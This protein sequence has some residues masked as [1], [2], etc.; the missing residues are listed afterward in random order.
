LCG[1]SAQLAEQR[2]QA[3]FRQT[4]ARARAVWKLA[5]SVLEHARL[6]WKPSN[7]G[8]GRPPGI[9]QCRRALGAAPSMRRQAPDTNAAAS[10]SRNTIAAETSASVP[11]RDAGTCR[12]KPWISGFIAAG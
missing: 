7:A 6:R 8:D 11:S 9:G 2:Q 5:P 1:L 4:P 3:R 10:E 12:G